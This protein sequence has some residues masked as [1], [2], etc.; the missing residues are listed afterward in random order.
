MKKILQF[1]C[2]FAAI[3]MFVDGA[4]SATRGTN[5][6]N[7]SR[8]SSVSRVGTDNAAVTRVV[9]GATMRPTTTNVSTRGAATVTSR[10]TSERESV[11]ATSSRAATRRPVSTPRAAA[12]VPTVNI[13][14]RAATTEKSTTSAAAETR[15]G[16]EYEKCKA[17]Y[18]ECMDQFCKLKNDDY[19]RCSCSD[20]VFDLAASRK[21]LQDAGQQLTV[22]TEN[23]DVVGMTA[24]QATAMRTESEGENALTA[25]TSASKALLQAI[26][27]SIRGEDTNVG[28][29]YSSLNSVNL[30]F[31]TTNAFGMQDTGQVIAQYNGQ[32]LY[33][34]VY[35]QCRSAVRADCNDA[36]LQRAITAYLMA[37]EQDCNTVQT[38]IE[39]TRKQVKASIREGSAMLDLARVEN[40]KNHNSDDITTC[41]NNVEAAILSEQVCGAGYHKCLDNG[42]FID[43]ATGTPI[44]GVERFYELERLLTFADGVDAANQKLSQVQSN[45]AFVQTFESRTKK[46][47]ADALDKCVEQADVVW[48]EYLDKALLAIYYAQKAK[49][50]QIKEGCFDF[51]SSCYVNGDKA[52]TAAMKELAGDSVVL[53]QPDKITLTSTMCSDY[54]D[55]CNYMFDGD[56]ISQYIGK[57]TNTDTL[58]ACR[59]VAQQCFDSFGGAN[60][61]N[62]YY[63][64]SGIFES[65]QALDWFTLYE[66]TTV[67][68][69][70]TDAIIVKRKSD[71]PV[72]RCAQQ[73]AEIDSC[74]T[75]ETLQQVFGGFDRARV[76]YTDTNGGEYSI[77][78]VGNSF[79]YGLVNKVDEDTYSNVLAWRNRRMVG[80]ATE[81][82]NQVID[83]L[84]IQCMNVQGEF[85]EYKDVDPEL[86]SATNACL[87]DIS[88]DNIIYSEERYAGTKTTL[89]QMYGLGNDE[90][91]CPKDYGLNVDMQSWGMC[92]CWENGA[93]RSKNGTSAKCVPAFP[94]AGGS[95]A[96]GK[97]C[98]TNTE[99]KWG[100]TRYWCDANM[101]TPSGLVCP[102]DGGV[103]N[104][105]QCT[106]N[107]NVSITGLPAPT[108]H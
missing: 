98:N 83:I 34:A 107:Q 27:N 31:D 20:R 99:I 58:A 5:S 51:V 96:V 28:G 78:P 86:Y 54:I 7:N 75:E 15:T 68:D 80:V 82:Y 39:T 70:K 43:V 21:T 38:A 2:V 35:P 3:V 103:S 93:R 41:I 106:T 84:R 57:H 33:S 87:I 66:Y 37:V 102:P 6:Q 16:A 29:K 90:N 26:M 56:I 74:N 48:A 97:K 63:P 49:V 32:N 79:E 101:T 73:L 104:D 9:R 24:A 13:T 76:S 94:V 23:L 25:D 71:K 65:G 64:Y 44:A 19:R 1:V 60:F 89:A 105:G 10:S 47:A 12:V 53:M 67:K 108:E 22:F 69:E 92:S 52:L 85:V 36:S 100:N 91:I 30:A 42:E 18:F 62:F 11:R 77:D 81:I 50:E 45:R 61:E 59:A 8:N 17:T 88:S 14:A 72:S 40:R 46:F 4:V 95:D 55:S